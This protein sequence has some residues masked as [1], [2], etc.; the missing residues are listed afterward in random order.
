MKG[1]E[2]RVAQLLTVLEKEERV[3][4]TR[5]AEIFG[6]SLPTARRLCA[7]M[8]EEGLGM[9]IHGGLR[10]IPLINTKYTFDDVE[11]E[12]ILEKKSIASAACDLI[13]SHRT[14]YLESGTTIKQVA[15][16]LADRIRSGQITNVNVFTNSLVNLD[17]LESLCPV[18]LIG[19]LYRPDRRAFSGLLCERMIR[20]LHFDI[21]FTGADAISLTDGIMATDVETARL[22]E[23][24]IKC[25][26]QSIVLAHSEKFKKR[27]LISYSSVY[28]VTAFITDNNIPASI[29]QAFLDASI[30]VITV[31]VHS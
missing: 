29:K 6:I 21:C 25:S 17:I 7:Q 2:S 9:R 20:S 11:Q 10:Y 24:L 13:E 12:F 30:K 5:I 15:I 28:A 1:K 16:A 3:A 19:G 23:E 14:V 26:T 8:E 4:T 22:D 31:P 18:N 27:S